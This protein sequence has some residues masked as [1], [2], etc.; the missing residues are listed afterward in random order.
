MAS[1]TPRSGNQPTPLHID[2][3]SAILVARN[4][5]KTKRRKNI[6]IKAHHI[7]HHHGNNFNALQYLPSHK[8]LSDI[9]TKSLDTTPF[10]RLKDQL[11]KPPPFVNRT[12]KHPGV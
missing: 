12:S 1:I 5:S 4:Q 8:N 6:D 3:L 9:L 2:N 7:D 10:T 11:V